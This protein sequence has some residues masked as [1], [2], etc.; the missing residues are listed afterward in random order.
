MSGTIS[1]GL[2]WA[3]GLDPAGLLQVYILILHI[4]RGIT[5][6]TWTMTSCSMV[7]MEEVVDRMELVR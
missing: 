3:M 2:N 7:R 6:S 5:D 1:N 4:L